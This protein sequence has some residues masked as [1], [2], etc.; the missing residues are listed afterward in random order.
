LT[1]QALRNEFSF[2]WLEVLG[3]KGCPL[4]GGLTGNLAE[5][6]LLGGDLYLG[7]VNFSLK[8]NN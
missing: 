8:F 3:F 1:S 2:N 6:L 4:A 5:P 7:L